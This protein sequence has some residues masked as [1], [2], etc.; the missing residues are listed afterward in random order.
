MVVFTDIHGNF[1]TFLALYNKVPK[2]RRDKG[3]AIAGDLMDRGP[4]SKHMIQWCIDHPEVKVIK[5]NHEEL[6]ID[7]GLREASYFIKNCTFN[8]YGQGGIW[9]MNG[10]FQTLGS[11]ITDNGDDTATFDMSTFIDHLEWLK[12]LPYY[13]EFKNVKNDKGEHLLITH[14]SAA[15][16][17]KWS[18]EKR[19]ENNQQFIGHITWGRPNTIHAIPNVYNIFGHT[20]NPNGP[21]IKSCYANIDTGCFYNS[22]P[23]Y[24][25]LTAI[26]FPSLETWEQGNIDMNK[27]VEYE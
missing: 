14:S 19:K 23:G 15:S 11:Y 4:K 10:G 6:M 3:V 25:R 21:K 13:L 1:E 9:G 8:Y 5:G 17:W 16:V 20:P 2:E 18:E 7:E 12:N 27:K 22:A 24:F 26:E